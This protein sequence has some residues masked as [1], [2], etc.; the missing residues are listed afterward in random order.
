[1]SIDTVEINAADKDYD[2]AFVKFF[3]MRAARSR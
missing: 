3:R 1:M 2:K